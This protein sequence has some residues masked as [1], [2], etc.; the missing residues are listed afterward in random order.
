ML[1]LVDTHCHLFLN[2]FDFDFDDVL[3]RGIRSGVVRFVNPGI[4]LITSKQAIQL[5][6]SHP[7]IYAAVGIHPT[8][9]EGWNDDTI[10]AI[11]DLAHHPKVIAIGEIGLDYY[12]DTTPKDVQRRILFAQ[13]DLARQ[14]SLPVILHNRQSM[15]DM[16]SILTEWCT[17]LQRQSSPL[18]ER[19]GVL[20]SFEGSLVEAEKALGLGF[21]L[22]VSGPVTFRNA[23]ERQALIAALP[24]ERLLLETDAPFLTPQPHRGQRN[25][26]AYV[27]LVAEKVADLHKTTLPTVAE[28]TT[29]NAARLFQWGVID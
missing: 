3:Q 14:L 29:S 4:D 23:P 24:M 1:S 6:E 25:E 27:L 5:A 21:Y 20:H 26:P 15:D 16:L 11:N 9:C 13:L 2:N 28:S 7:E 17:D 19:P 8:E 22:G 18:A 12:H 10:A